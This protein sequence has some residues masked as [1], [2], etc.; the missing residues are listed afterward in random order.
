MWINVERDFAIWAHT[1][2]FL[3]VLKVLNVCV[4]RALSSELTDLCVESLADQLDERAD[5][6][7]PGTAGLFA[8]FD[9]V[10]LQNHLHHDLLEAIPFGGAEAVLVFQIDVIGADL[11]QEFGVH[12]TLNDLVEK[13]KKILGVVGN[14]ANSIWIGGERVGGRLEAL[15]D[16]WAVGFESREATSQDNDQSLSVNVSPRAT[17]HI[18]LRRCQLRAHRNNVP[19]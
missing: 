7:T 5:E 11:A 8:L 14:G 12:I 10:L 2:A 17:D 4:E 15:G 1:D 9:A 19:W 13:L 3:D 16:D 18:D 6:K